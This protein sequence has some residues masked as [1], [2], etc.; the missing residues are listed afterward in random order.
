MKI[1]MHRG[2]LDESLK[3]LE[4]IEPTKDSIE[5][6]ISKHDSFY[7]GVAVDL[8]AEYR[9]DRVGWDKTYI[10]MSGR[11]PVAFCDQPMQE[12]PPVDTGVGLAI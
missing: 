12:T 4:E 10:V 6:Y 3:T 7:G 5:A 11:F 2:A 1:R 8:Y 9:D